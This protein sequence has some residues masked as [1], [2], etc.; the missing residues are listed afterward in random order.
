ME[1]SAQ[2]IREIQFREKLRGYHPDDVDEFLSQVATVVEELQRQV[3]ELVDRASTAEQR[4]AELAK[5]EESL[6]RT[7]VLAQ[8]TADLALREA[9]EEASVL[10]AE[11]RAERDAVV[12]GTEE[13]RRQL[14]DEV[15]AEVRSD[16]LRLHEQREQLQA[17]VEA[18]A[19]F[20][21]AE[22]A[23]LR[24]ALAEQ[25]R[26]LDTGEF[27]V[28]TPPELHDVSVVASPATDDGAGGDAGPTPVAEVAT[29]DDGA[30]AE[31][32]DH[33]E[34][35]AELRRAVTDTSP[36]GPR[37]DDRAEPL[38]GEHEHDIFEGV[39]ADGGRFTS[40]LRRRR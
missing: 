19:A 16:L 4:V 35:L 7:L 37:D 11:A 34:F 23:R 13:L 20:V 14:V 6:H 38:P 12:A 31:D 24:A 18:L 28:S 33:D 21:D 3:H 39:D 26:R 8:R 32:D 40:R 36:L 25:L 2:S 1:L 5:T 22:R 15:Q 10:V 30:S 27:V 29:A 9:R 17:D